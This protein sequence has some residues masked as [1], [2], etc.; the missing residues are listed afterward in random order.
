M[1]DDMRQALDERHHLIEQ[2]ARALAETALADDE[3]WTRHLGDPPGDAR[4]RAVWVRRVETIAT[5]R[6]RYDISADT[7]LG[8]PPD[9]I[10]QRVDAARARSA[11]WSTRNGSERL[12]GP[13]AL[14]VHRQLAGTA[15]SG[16]GIAAPACS[17]RVTPSTT[18]RFSTRST[19]LRSRHT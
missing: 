14:L 6:D 18:V 15:P 10:A 1:P 4:R 19:A 2:R 12:T 16:Y 3:P 7:P 13:T 11:G 8:P 9:N 5:Y 17:S